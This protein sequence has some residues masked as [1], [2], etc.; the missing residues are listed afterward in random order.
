LVATGL[1]IEN[2]PGLA[3]QRAE[4]SERKPLRIVLRSG[5]KFFALRRLSASTAS[6]F[7]PAAAAQ[8]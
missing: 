5:Q 1:V 2:P 4:I 8:Q 7:Q 6:A 3:E